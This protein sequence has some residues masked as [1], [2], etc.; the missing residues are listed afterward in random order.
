MSDPSGGTLAPFRSMNVT[1]RSLL[2]GSVLVVACGFLTAAQPAPNQSARSLLVNVLDRNGNPVRDLTKDSF[3][4]KVNGHPTAIVEAKYVA[5]PRRVVVLLDTSNSM[6][7]NNPGSNKWRIAREALED[8]LK[9]TPAEEQIAL[10]T[11]STKVN[12]VI[13]FSQG[14]AAIADWLKGEPSQ[15][16]NLKGYTAFFDAVGEATKL[17]QPSR[18][19]DAVYAITDGGDNR[20]RTSSN[21]ARKVLLGSGIRLFVFLLALPLQ[22]EE[23]RSGRES[24]MEL[25]QATGGFSVV[26]G[27]LG[28][29]TESEYQSSFE[30]AYTY[31]ERVREK[32]RLYTQSVN[33]EVNGFYTLNLEGPLDSRREEKVFLNVADRS[34]RSRKDLAFT[35]PKALQS[36]AK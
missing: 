12:D 11:F 30:L 15:G 34:G 18:S 20:S 21:N 3:R 33:T 36:Q 4:V 29:P 32:I 27:L 35:Y 7:G 19:G 8:L 2:V 13:G 28:H 26:F 14:R 6:S 9:E 1:K 24:V 31:D 10:L 5:A 23:E 16:S 25:A 17:L 22:S